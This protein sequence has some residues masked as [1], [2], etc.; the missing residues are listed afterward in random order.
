MAI[1]YVNSGAGGANDGTSWTDAWTSL[2]S[3][4]GVAAGDEVR[5]HNA[6]SQDPGA[7]VTYNWSNGTE[8]SPVKIV[9]VNKDASDA[10]ATGATIAQTVAGRNIVLQGSLYVDGMTFN[11]A[12][13]FTIGTAN[14]SQRYSTCTLGIVVTTATR[15]LTS[16]GSP[17]VIEIYNSTINVN[18][19]ANTGFTVGG[20]DRVT[21]VNSTINFHASSASGPTVSIAGASLEMRCCDIGGST[22]QFVAVATGARIDAYRCKLGSFT[23]LMSTAMGFAS[24][25][26]VGECSAATVTGPTFG[27]IGYGSDRGRVLGDSGRSRT[28][29]ATRNSVG[30]SWEMTPS[31][32]AEEQIHPLRTPDFAIK[33]EGGAARTLTVYVAGGEEMYNDEVWLEIEGPD[34]SNT[35]QGYYHSTRLPWR[36]ARVVLDTAS[37]ST[38]SGAGTG[39]ERKIDHTYTPNHD[40]VVVIRVC[41]GKTSGAAIYVD[42]QIVVT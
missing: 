24:S 38:W 13:T 6:H 22:T 4:T 10:L 33:V 21:I 30:F 9:C 8:A 11:A 27:L 5:V 41:Y 26:T 3:S 42:P 17:A 2:A 40:G 23:N 32:T 34:D 31:A 39:T 35:T 28:G 29:G 1:H 36:G 12:D 16:A 25:V 18:V 20:R 7:S 15:A 14:K 19:V 37:P